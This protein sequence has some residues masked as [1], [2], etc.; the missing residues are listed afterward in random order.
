MQ[1]SPCCGAPTPKPVFPKQATR[2]LSRAK[3]P[4]SLFATRSQHLKGA[5]TRRQ[6]GTPTMRLASRSGSLL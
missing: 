5:V 6:Y 2:Q 3:S 1:A 4:T